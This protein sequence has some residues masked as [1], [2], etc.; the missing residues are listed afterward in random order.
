MPFQEDLKELKNR[1]LL[2]LAA[3]AIAF[4][5]FYTYSPQVMDFIVTKGNEAGYQFVYINP[6]EVLVQQIKIASIAS[7][8]V[9]I[10]LIIIEASLFIGPGI[11]SGF[12]GVMLPSIFACVMFILGALF[13]YLV[14]VPF[15]FNS[16]YDVGINAKI[17]AQVS[18]ENYISLYLV[19]IVALGIIFEL[20]L[21]TLGL[22]KFGIIDSNKMKTG[23]KIAI[24]IAFIIAAL[25]TPPDVF[26]QAV[27][28]VPI[29]ILYQ[30]SIVLCKLV[31]RKQKKCDLE[32]QS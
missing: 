32:L 16:L 8:I 14:L 26:S 5:L 22:T 18:I 17:T 13:S 2:I 1:I 11:D 6:A 12:W 27:V 28:A 24:V 10:P 21:V 31:E 3:F 29:I 7:I 19:L 30:F 20:P 9:I 23:R 25:I 4:I 15:I